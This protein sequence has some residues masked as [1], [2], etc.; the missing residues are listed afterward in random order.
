MVED[1]ERYMLMELEKKLEQGPV[2]VHPNEVAKIGAQYEHELSEHQSYRLFNRLHR[3]GKIIGDPA[4]V[5]DH[6]AGWI[7]F[8]LEDVQM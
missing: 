2:D 3:Q 4:T 1:S 5:T 7:M 6:P 8:W